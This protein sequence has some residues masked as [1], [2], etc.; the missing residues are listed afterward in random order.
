MKLAIVR[1]AV[2]VVMALGVAI[3][4]ETI[5]LECQRIG[6]STSWALTL[7]RVIIGMESFVIS[8]FFNDM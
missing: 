1:L 8:I 2:V 7:G 4:M 3:F 5:E 6:I